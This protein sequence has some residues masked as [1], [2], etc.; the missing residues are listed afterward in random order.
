MADGIDLEQLQAWVGDLLAR[1]DPGPRRRVALRIAQRIRRANADRIGD[2]VQPDGSPFVPRKPQKGARGRVGTIKQRRQSRKM[3]A[4]LRQFRLL[5]AE[6]TPD[7]AIV[8][9]RNAATARVARVHQ[10][11]LRDRVSR[12]G[13]AP[14]V[15]YPERVLLGFGAGDPNAVLDLLLDSLEDGR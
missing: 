9:F 10:L 7:E 13:D 11:G 4:K 5:S 8:G 3:F 15:D 14:E 2:Q 12:A 1:L 6:A